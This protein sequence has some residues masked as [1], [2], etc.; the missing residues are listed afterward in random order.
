MSEDKQRD[1]DRVGVIGGRG[2]FGQ[3][4]VQFFE[5][6]GHPVLLSDKGSELSNSDLAR[7][8]TIV[9]VAVPISSTEGVLREIAQCIDSQ[10]LLIDLTSVKL[11][12]LQL[13][14]QLPCE[15]LSLHPMFSPRLGA[16]RGQSC[17]VC[18]VKVGGRSGYVE[19]LLEAEGLTLVSMD[20]DAHD[21][22]MAV[23][24]G[25]THF[26][27]IAAAHCMRALGFDPSAS[28]SSASPVYRLRLSMI[29]RILAQDARLYAE[30]QTYNPYVAQVLTVLEQSSALLGAKVKA[31]DIEGFIAEFE[32][33]KSAFAD[34]TR[35]AFEES[36]RLIRVLADG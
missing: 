15:V 13:Q 33:V 12:F 1:K 22:M 9:V 17:V 6:A 18:R 7:S 25:L 28:I 34:F 4:M 21:R 16:H 2:A 29:G 8:C 11:P 24:Q 20:S 14:Q 35:E 27:A 30:I 23:V 32:G 10:T 19:R 31:K 36:D 3:W 5:R 26:Q